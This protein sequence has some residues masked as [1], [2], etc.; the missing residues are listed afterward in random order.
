M[1]ERRMKIDGAKLTAELQKRGVTKGKASEEIGMNPNYLAS[2]T[3]AGGISRVAVI[4]LQKV[5]NIDP[6]S[7]E[8]K[9]EPDDDK[10]DE[11]LD[12]DKLY[13]II[14]TAVYN[15]MKVALES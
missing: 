2:A 5:Y 8:L 1:M 7:Y 13:R 14:Y 10:P 11:K 6:E 12:D 4:A 9:D 15:A 3:H